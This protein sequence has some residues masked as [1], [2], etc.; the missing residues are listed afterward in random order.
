[1][2][3][4]KPFSALTRAFLI[5]TIPAILLL[6]FLY[7]AV[8]YGNAK[9]NRV[10]IE[11]N[12]SMIVSSVERSIKEISQASADCIYSMDYV[13]FAQSASLE[14]VSKYASNMTAKLRHSLSDNPEVV[15]F[16]LY[17]SGCDKHF[18]TLIN[19]DTKGFYP[20]YEFDSIKN[21]FVG[22]SDLEYR[23]VNE[24]CYIVYLYKQAYGNIAVYID[25]ALNESYSSYCRA[26][27]KSNILRF[28]TIPSSDSDHLKQ[29]CHDFDDL[30]LHL[31]WD[32]RNNGFSKVQHFTQILVF[33]LLCS[34][35]V[36]IVYMGRTMQTRLIEPLTL[37]WN[38]FGKI[39]DGQTDYR[40]S[41]ETSL[42]EQ[43]RQYRN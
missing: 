26:S 28:T 3:N 10:I 16:V 14:K 13:A 9:N 36:V 22:K 24:K 38:A 37:L 20:T 11:N 40:I 15:G 31:V 35:I 2:N 33:L 7:T 42:G 17:N 18:S 6:I 4:R 39:S 21:S 8:L 34:L 23:E 27:A 32:S 43:L 41:A 5:I 19:H 25:P 1:M 29:I 30:P 12:E